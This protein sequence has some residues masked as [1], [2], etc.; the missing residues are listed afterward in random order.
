MEACPAAE[1]TDGF[2]EEGL[3]LPI[4]QARLMVERQQHTV[5]VE[6]GDKAAVFTVQLSAGPTLLHTW[7]DDARGEPICGAYYV[8]VSRLDPTQKYPHALQEVIQS[9]GA[10]VR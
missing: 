10:L 4:A 1:L 9:K 7:F 6:P 5:T 3:A 8:Y 2:M